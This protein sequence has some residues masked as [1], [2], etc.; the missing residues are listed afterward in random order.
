MWES[1]ERQRTIGRYAWVMAWFGL[2]AGQ[3]H[4]LARH[5]TVD[6]KNDLTLPLTRLWSDPTRSR[7]SRCWTGPTRTRCT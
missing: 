2:V 4:A 3:L 7:W 5:N 1:V 6:G